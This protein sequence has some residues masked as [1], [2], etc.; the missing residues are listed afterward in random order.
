M[1]DFIEM[2]EEGITICEFQH[3]HMGGAFFYL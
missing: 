3:G 2:C 1:P